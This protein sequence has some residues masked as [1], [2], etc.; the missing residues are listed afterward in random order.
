MPN[1]V[2]CDWSTWKHRSNADY[3]LYH[4]NVLAESILFDNTTG[5]PLIHANSDIAGEGV[6]QTG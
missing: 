4:T 5:I 3:D 6:S 2:I 1:E